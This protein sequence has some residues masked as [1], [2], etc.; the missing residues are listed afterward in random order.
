[1]FISAV[2]WSVLI[3]LAV[4]IQ[5]LLFS[6]QLVEKLVLLVQIQCQGCL[7]SIKPTA[8]DS[9]DLSENQVFVY[10]FLTDKTHKSHYCARCRSNTGYWRNDEM[11]AFFFFF[12]N[13]RLKL[14]DNSSSNQCFC[15]AFTAY[16]HFSM[17]R[18]KPMAKIDVS[19][20]EESNFMDITEALI[21]GCDASLWSKPCITFERQ[22]SILGSRIF[23]VHKF[24]M[25]LQ[26]GAKY[27]DPATFPLVSATSSPSLYHICGD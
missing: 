15:L 23:A 2:F 18:Q 19:Y 20:F 4:V 3:N 22:P 25:I 13:P 17:Y 7:S 26:Y 9:S 6:P 10:L 1:M 16:C 24:N 5:S 27:D 21:V 12:L 11:T 8:L 14:G